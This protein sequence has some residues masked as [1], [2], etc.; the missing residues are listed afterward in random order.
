[1][2]TQ[3]AGV[4]ELGKADTIIVRSFTVVCPH[5]SEEQGGW[6]ASPGN[7]EYA[8]DDCG[9]PYQVVDTP[10]IRFS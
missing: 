10:N 6:I 5:C 2:S 4:P 8:C 3:E 1:M 7:G 9:K